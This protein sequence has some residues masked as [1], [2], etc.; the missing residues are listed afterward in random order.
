[1]KSIFAIVLM[2]TMLFLVPAVFA[3]EVTCPEHSYATCF[4]TGE[5]KQAAD[6]GLMHL[7]HC[8]CGDSWWVRD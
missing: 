6:G 1:M 7:Y 8:T 5:I 2:A 3:A 4:R